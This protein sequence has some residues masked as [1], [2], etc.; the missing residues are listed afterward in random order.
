MPGAGDD[1][2][3]ACFFTHEVHGGVDTSGL[4]PDAKSEVAVP[5]RTIAKAATAAADAAA[6]AVTERTSRRRSTCVRSSD[7]CTGQTAVESWIT[8]TSAAISC[9]HALHAAHPSR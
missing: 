7:D 3:S 2:V 5:G 1:T 4:L 6:E 9:D 8:V